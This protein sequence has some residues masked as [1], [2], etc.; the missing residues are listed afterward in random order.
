MNQGW[1]FHFT[2]HA[3]AWPQKGRGVQPARLFCASSAPS[4]AIG[5]ISFGELEDPQ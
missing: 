3:F 4:S 2:K 5:L 1:F